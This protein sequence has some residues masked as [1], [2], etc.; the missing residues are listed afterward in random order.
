MARI[1]A[2]RLKWE[3]HEFE[4]ILGYMARSLTQKKWVALS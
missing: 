1:P 4:A 3:D 2:V